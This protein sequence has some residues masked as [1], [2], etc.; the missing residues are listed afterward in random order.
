MN[1]CIKVHLADHDSR[2]LVRTASGGVADPGSPQHYPALGGDACPRAMSRLS[3]SFKEKMEE[4]RAALDAGAADSS[5]VAVRLSDPTYSA[6]KQ[7]SPRVS[8]ASKLVAEQRPTE[9]RA[10]A[11]PSVEIVPATSSTQQVVKSCPAGIL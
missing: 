4:G 1:T 9:L 8:K 2:S 5:D 7:G 10:R 3:G 11:G 6:A